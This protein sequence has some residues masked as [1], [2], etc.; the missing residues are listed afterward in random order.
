MEERSL[1]SHQT[2][3]PSGDNARQA[4]EKRF[5]EVIYNSRP[6]TQCVRVSLSFS[7]SH[8]IFRTPSA[9]LCDAKPTASGGERRHFRAFQSAALYGRDFLENL[10]SFRKLGSERRAITDTL[11][12][13]KSFDHESKIIDACLNNGAYTT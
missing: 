4:L 7:L 9:V 13:S 12:F 10:R 11:K 2:C 1:Q 6:H 8:V 5:Q 3:K